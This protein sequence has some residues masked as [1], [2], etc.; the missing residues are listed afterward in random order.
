MTLPASQSLANSNQFS[1][2]TDSISIDDEPKELGLPTTEPWK[3]LYPAVFISAFQPLATGSIETSN[4]VAVSALL[5][6]RR[7]R[8]KR[9]KNQISQG[10]GAGASRDPVSGRSRRRRACDTKQVG[11]GGERDG[12]GGGRRRD[13]KGGIV[14]NLII[15]N[16]PVFINFYHVNIVILTCLLACFFQTILT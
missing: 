2:H 7:G 5:L 12:K 6:P 10:V 14:G 15:L 13:G 1:I 11:G 8:L 16:L 4:A 9:S 3:S